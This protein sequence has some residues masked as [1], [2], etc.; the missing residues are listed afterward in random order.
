MHKNV[1]DG[2]SASEISKIIPNSEIIPEK[3]LTY[4]DNCVLVWGHR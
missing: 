4:K 2:Y 3:P 1:D